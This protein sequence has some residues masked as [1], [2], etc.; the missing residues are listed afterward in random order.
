L[1]LSIASSFFKNA[2]LK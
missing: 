1:Y 2:L